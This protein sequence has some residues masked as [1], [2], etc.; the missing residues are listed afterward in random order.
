MRVMTSSEI[1]KEGLEEFE[2]IWPQLDALIDEFVEEYKLKSNHRSLTRT[3]IKK[4]YIKYRAKVLRSYM[5]KGTERIDKHKIAACMM[6]ATCVVHP[7]RFSTRDWFLIRFS[8]DTIDKNKEYPHT[9]EEMM[10]ANECLALSIAT[11]IVES[12]IAAHYKNGDESQPLLHS[13][14]FPEP[15]PD[16]DD[17]YFRDVCV[18]LYYTRSRQ[19]SILTYSDIFFLWE[20]YSCRYDQ[21]ENLADKYR[22]ILSESGMSPAEIE[23]AVDAV[24]FQTR[25]ITQ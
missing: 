21:C 12:Y 3:R 7:L 9:V 11:S 13:I 14:H 17:N 16:G 25:D 10:I 1:C 5:A 22:E 23:K 8:P 18:D 19:I 15:F 6:K 2:K 20:K 24:R 4:L